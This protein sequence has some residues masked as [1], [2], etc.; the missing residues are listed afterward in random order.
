MG[1]ATWYARVAAQ[2]PR[3]GI[4]S[5]CLR[6]YDKD[7][8]WRG[9]TLNRTNSRLGIGSTV[10]EQVPL[11]TWHR[12]DCTVCKLIRHVRDHKQRSKSSSTRTSRQYDMTSDFQFMFPGINWSIR[13]RLPLTAL[14]SDAI[15]QLRRNDVRMKPR[16]RLQCKRRS[17]IA[18]RSGCRWKC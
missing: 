16:R 2:K 11:E 4:N 8:S 12:I 3:R 6:T 14:A 17:G 15:R 18:M 9:P 5:S 7:R 13:P 1:V 10:K